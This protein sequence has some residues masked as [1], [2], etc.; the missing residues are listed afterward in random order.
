MTKSGT[1]KKHL[2][3]AIEGYD[4]Q[5]ARHS[6]ALKH[7]NANYAGDLLRDETAKENAA[8]TASL[9][10]IAEKLNLVSDE[11]KALTEKAYRKLSAPVSN[12]TFNALQVFRMRQ[13]VT[14]A[15]IESFKNRHGDNLNVL[16]VL[17][18]IADQHGVTIAEAFE[19]KAN[20]SDGLTPSGIL[21]ALDDL[22]TH[23]GQM[24]E[25]ITADKGL[26]ALAVTHNLATQKADALG[27]HLDAIA[28]YAE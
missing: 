14:K 20:G 25:G 22:Q 27:G 16:A 4:F 12:E 24:Q 13:S 2:S 1:L 3:A 6:N 23:I 26:L 15:E 7:L 10:S 18:E 9:S 17:N 28:S 11:V 8:H 5:I 21:S 19:E